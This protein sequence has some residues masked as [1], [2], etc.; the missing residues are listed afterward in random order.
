MFQVSA[1]AIT[2]NM[3]EGKYEKP[4]PHPLTGRRVGIHGPSGF[5]R[6]SL[7]GKADSAAGLEEFLGRDRESHSEVR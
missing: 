3:R 7:T 5:Y 4:P 1:H 6:E 2:R